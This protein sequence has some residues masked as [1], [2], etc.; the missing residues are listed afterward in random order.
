MKLIQALLIVVVSIIYGLPNLI[1]L[2]RL[3]SSY[4]P[5]TL[6]ATSPIARDEAFAYGPETNYVLSEKSFLKEIYTKE[7]RDLPTPFIGETASAIMLAVLAFISGSVENA[8]II[9]DFIF[10]PIVFLGFF[11]FT[12]I[13]VKNKLWAMAAALTAV[14][15]RDFVAVVPY[16][17]ETFKYLTTQEGQNY[18]LYLSR[19]FHP[20]TSL[21]FFSGAVIAMAR[22]VNNP[23][24][25][26]NALLLGIL[27][28]V[29]FYTY[30][31]NW[32]LFLVFFLFVFLYFL[33]KK[34]YQIVKSLIIAGAVALFISSFYLFKM[35]QFYQLSF[36]DDFITKTSLYNVPIPLTLIRYLLL[37]LAFFVFFKKKDKNF[38]LLLILLL[39]GVAITPFSKLLV[40][41]DLE[42]FHY[43]RR[44][45][46][47]FATLTLFII[48]HEILKRSKPMTNLLAV[49]TISIF[50]V[51]GFRVQIIGTN[52]I[53][54]SHI[55]N[56]DMENVFK[57]LN[58]NVPKYSV[59][60]SLSPEFSSLIPLYTRNYV[61]FPP[62]DRTIM[63]TYEGVEKYKI[64]SELLGVTNE[65]QEQ[66]LKDSVS[67]FFV[68]QS[69]NQNRNLDPNS[70]RRLMAQKQI[71]LLEKNERWKEKLSNYKLDYIVITPSEIE[72]VKPNTS[73]LQFITSMNGYLIFASK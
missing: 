40:G 27:F 24:K 52:K 69:Y 58:R 12:K 59:L 61:Y 38:Y 9:S 45:V 16:P 33:S 63:P 56:Q 39:S 15:S 21:I 35:Y 8:F 47:P 54:A 71:E 48:F 62:T 73:Y 36:I 57:W 25:I 42:T 28:G 26:T 7:Y 34:E 66:K 10:P 43:L 50:L 49:F 41:Q 1:L 55:K 60:G 68:F 51:Y 17:L 30:V 72:H 14:I 13:F 5:F 4:T 64:L 23:Q 37:S 29:L 2:E 19:A 6:S 11:Y 18:L 44:I 46:M 65:W 22:I 32:T 3:G 67:Y 31:F 70:P 20:Q 53:S